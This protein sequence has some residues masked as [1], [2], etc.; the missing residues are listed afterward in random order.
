MHRCYLEGILHRLRTR[1]ILHGRLQTN[2]HFAPIHYSILH[3]SFPATHQ[4]NI[5]IVALNKML[6]SNVKIYTVLLLQRFVPE[7]STHN[8]YI[9]LSE[10]VRRHICKETKHLTF[11]DILLCSGVIT[12]SKCFRRFPERTR[13]PVTGESTR[14]VLRMV[15]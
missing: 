15:S 6:Q 9:S 10:Y 12:S 4:K 2:N 8:L 1:V 14:F 11:V 13:K 3:H 7:F 5:A